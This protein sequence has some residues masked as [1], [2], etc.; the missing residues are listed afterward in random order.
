[1]K[2]EEIVEKLQTFSDYLEVGNILS[3][4]LRWLGWFL[5]QAL[6]WLVD[7]L[8][9]ITDSI[10]GIKTFFNSPDVQGFIKDI[11]PFLYVLLAFS[12]LYIGYLLIMNK[13]L[14]REQ[15]MFNLFIS[16]GV[17]V[18]LNVG[19]LKADKFTDEAVDAVDLNEEGTT[20]EKIIKDGITDIAQIDVNGWKTT[21]LKKPNK[22]PQ[23]NIKMIDITEKID[24]KFKINK[25]KELSNDGKDILQK[26][27]A[28]NGEGKEGLAKLD[29]G[30]FD[31]FPEQYYRW[32]WD[33]WTIAITLFVTGMTLLFIT[34]KLAKLCYELAFNS[35][36]A[37]L[38]APADVADGQKLKQVLKSIMN[39]FLIIIMIFISMKV[40]LMG[41]QFIS[42]KLD[43]IAYL[44]ALIAISIAV[45]DGPVMC[46][47]IFGI[48]AGLKSG[49]AAVAGGMA[50]A[51]GA[52]SALG[53]L[54]KG[55]AALGKLGKSGVGGLSMAGGGVAGMAAGLAKGSGQ[56]QGKQDTLPEQMKKAMG[57]GQGKGQQERQQGKG[58]DL[59]SHMPGQEQ[60]NGKMGQHQAQANGMNQGTSLQEEMKAA[61]SQEGSAQGQDLSSSLQ[62]EKDPSSTVGSEG[63][64]T[65]SLQDEMKASESETNASLGSPSGTQQGSSQGQTTLRDEMKAVEGKGGFSSSQGSPSPSNGGSRTI[66]TSSVQGGNSLQNEIKAS[67]GTQGSP[68]PSNGGSQ[69]IDTPSI[70]RGSSLQQ[71][72]NTSGEVQGS[73]SSLN[74]ESRTV[75][76]P[77]I[78][79][80][81][82]LQQEMNTSGGAQEISS[83]QSHGSQT[84]DT[85]PPVQSG[86]TLHQEMSSIGNASS[87]TEPSEAP[88]TI[89]S[90]TH[91]S[92]SVPLREDIRQAESQVAATQ[93]SYTVPVSSSTPVQN[94][95]PQEVIPS[96]TQDMPMP[97]QQRTE[98]RHIG[99]VIRD[100][101]SSAWN[102]AKTVQQTKR[103]YQIGRNTGEA[104]HRQMKPNQNKKK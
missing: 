38:L 35:I 86:T 78:Q 26:K 81:S 43:G 11:Q 18:L 102:G 25:D 9:G 85:P 47:R 32:H 71:E 79:G 2:D 30:W 16:I 1:M 21:D 66:D 103:T 5:I 90:V 63:P 20:S 14:N 56:G 100:K 91:T 8:E 19:M 64:G 22:V 36:L 58:S 83:P 40:Y 104:L 48:D 75:E 99:Q 84:I 44:I 29:N 27:L 94:T 88:S 76:T 67:G 101:A 52:E 95:S 62:G 87:Y 17:I 93:E 72:M 97:N 41:T 77:S 68:S 39:T 23:K 82:S 61:Q 4:C 59:T 80:S 37:Q 7:G 10:L 28:L 12:I 70:Q 51:K 46:E 45:V 24:D 50:L 65:T 74:S 15:I 98:T 42:D 3:Y 60:E 13:K 92:G 69:N 6:A 89:P 54:G 96:R 31:F 49:W 57:Q 34:I 33:F 55:S 73:P 53:A